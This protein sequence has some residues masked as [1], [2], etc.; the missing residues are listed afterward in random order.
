MGTH[1][2][3][4][5][6]V[7][8]VGVVGAWAMV[9]G[10]GGIVDSQQA[11]ASEAGQEVAAGQEAAATPVDAN[12]QREMSLKA[13]QEALPSTDGNAVLGCIDLF[14]NMS[15]CRSQSTLCCCNSRG[16]CGCF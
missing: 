15:C 9:T 7:V 11:F 4:W 1:V 16:T 8:V 12:S 2:K 10:S 6:R 5:L 13:L 3:R 14:F